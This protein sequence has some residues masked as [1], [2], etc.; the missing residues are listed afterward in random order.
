MSL[1]LFIH[2][3]LINLEDRELCNFPNRS[4]STSKLGSIIG[5]PLISGGGSRPYTAPKGVVL[6]AKWKDVLYQYFDH[7]RNLAQDRGI[8]ATK[9]T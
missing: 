8:G 2:T 9:A 3:P 5:V 6:V 7:G 1:D 4:L